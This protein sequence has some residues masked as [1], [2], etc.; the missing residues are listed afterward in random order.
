MADA[1]IIRS[2]PK[3]WT[4]YEKPGE[5]QI[6]VLVMQP[7][8]TFVVHQLES[9]YLPGV[10]GPYASKQEVRLAI[11]QAIGGDCHFWI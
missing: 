7:D 4:I 10:F 2:G 3:R 9:N 8:N 6:G 5:N 11:A 1:V